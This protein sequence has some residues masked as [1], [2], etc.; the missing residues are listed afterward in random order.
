MR[1]K[2]KKKK[3]VPKK[4]PLYDWVMGLGQ[5][6][7]FFKVPSCPYCGTGMKYGKTVSR[8]IVFTGKCT[9]CNGEFQ[10]RPGLRSLIFLLAVVLICVLL[11]HLLLFVATDMIPLFIWTMIPVIGAWFLWPLTLSVDK[12]KQK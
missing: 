3:P 7:T 8:F 11:C 2:A 6:K 9:H 4:P 5:R 12:K 1:I 10:C